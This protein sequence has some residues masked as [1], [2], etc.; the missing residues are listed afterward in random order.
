[1]QV[2]EIGDGLFHFLLAGAARPALEQ[3]RRRL[4]CASRWKLAIHRQYQLLIG[5][6]IFLRKHIC[7]R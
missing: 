2:H 5:K 3:V 1:V 4:L 6:M 7:H